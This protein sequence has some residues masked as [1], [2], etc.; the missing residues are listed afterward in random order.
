[1]RNTAQLP[2]ESRA[3]PVALNGNCPGKCGI[4]HAGRTVSGGACAAGLAVETVVLDSGFR[5]FGT[6]GPARRPAGTAEH[7]ETNLPA[8]PTQE[9]Q[10]A[11]FPRPH[12]IARRSPYTCSAPCQ[13]QK[14]AHRQ[15]RVT[16]GGA[17]SGQG[18]SDC[19]GSGAYADGL[20][21]G[22]SMIE[23]FGRGPSFS[24]CSFW[25][26][27]LAIPPGWA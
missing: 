25:R 9:S 22:Q 26:P 13:G 14:T 18:P 23:G 24:P 20:I 21:S 1:M 17:R 27:T 19:H 2:A 15:R 16:P 5:P 4:R 6:P 10:E 12:E 11:W 8:Q 3:G 7:A